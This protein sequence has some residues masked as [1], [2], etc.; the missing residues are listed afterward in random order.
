MI[1]A[2]FKMNGR[3]K[4]FTD[5]NVKGVIETLVKDYEEAI[6]EISGIIIE[7]VKGKEINEMTY[8]GHNICQS[9]IATIR[10]GLEI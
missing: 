7:E 10:N 4:T 6:P 9:W 3:D 1:T 2:T 5:E 8:K